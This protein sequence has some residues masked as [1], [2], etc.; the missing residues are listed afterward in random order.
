MT[1]PAA[2]SANHAAKRQALV[3][4]AIHV[5]WH[6][7]VEACTARAIADAS[8]LTKSALHYYFD[9]VDEILDLAFRHLMDEYISRF[10]KA[11]IDA[12]DPVTALWGAVEQYVAHGAE[13][14]GRAPLLWFDY[15][16]HSL[17]RGETATA[18]EL[19]LRTQRFFEELVEATGV[20]NGTERGRVLF[21]ALIGQVVVGSLEP[22]DLDASV[23]ELGASLGLPSPH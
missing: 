15:H 11:A 6:D 10:Q 14:P 17:R 19:T 12:P 23:A 21:A 5:L 3:D 2:F 18:A 9:D 8:P 16:V 7:G 13:R 1:E 20:A 4:A 22:R